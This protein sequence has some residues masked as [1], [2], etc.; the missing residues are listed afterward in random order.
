MRPDRGLSGAGGAAAPEA[1]SA[2]AG[3]EPP[4]ERGEEPAQIP[5]PVDPAL[6]RPDE[7]ITAICAILALGLI[8]LRAR[9]SSQ[10]SGPAPENRLDC[11]VR[12]SGHAAKPVLRGKRA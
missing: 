10:I 12:P 9:K 1:I 3:V 8:R 5:N 11:A 6:L 4:A 7:R 2:E